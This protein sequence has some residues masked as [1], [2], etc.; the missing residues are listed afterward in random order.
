MKIKARK[1]NNRPIKAKSGVPAKDLSP[2]I[3]IRLLEDRNKGQYK[4]ILENGTEKFFNNFKELKFFNNL[5]LR[6]KHKH[7][8][9]RREDQIVDC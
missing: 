3:A 9:I 1:T 4:L 7:I 2:I 5:N 6:N 8:I